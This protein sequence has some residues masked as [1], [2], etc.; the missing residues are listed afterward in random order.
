MIH[1][2]KVL[3]L[4]YL[5]ILYEIAVYLSN[6]M[7]LPSMPAIAKDLALSASQIQSTLTYWFLGAS[8]LQFVLGPISDRYGRKIVIVGGGILFVLSSAACAVAHNLPIML[9]ARFFQG[10]S[11]CSLVAAYAAIHELYSTKQAIKYL[12]LIGA[13]T[14]LAPALGPLF[15]AM[16]VQFAGW[17]D[18]FWFLVMLGLVSVLSLIAYMPESNMHRHPLHWAIIFKDY[19]KIVTNRHFMIPNMAYC[20]LVA[21]YFIWIFESPFIMIEVFQTTPL[22]Y[23]MAQTVIFGF[24]FIGAAVTKW[25]LDRY[26]VYRLIMVA[27]WI[28]IVGVV[29][30]LLTSIFYNNIELAILCMI[31][32]SFGTS[33]LFGPINRIAIETSTQPMGRRTAVFSTSISLFGALTGWVLT[34][35]N[36]RNL[37]TISTMI[38]LCMLVASLLIA[39]TKIPDFKNEDETLH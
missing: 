30:F 17:R 8:S 3:I 38:I 20:F 39:I 5:I 33:M 29:L 34:L 16:I 18:I 32:I 26:S 9:L 14:I 2:T 7:Y 24:Y 25:L 31:I 1:K 11:L 28:T 36:D 13:V 27:T 12:A 22:Y 37:L 21:M 6:D 4:P 10:I 23:G 19:K 35:I 15:G